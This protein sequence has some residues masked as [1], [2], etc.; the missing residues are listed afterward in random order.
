MCHDYNVFKTKEAADLESQ[1]VPP[2]AMPGFISMPGSSND[3]RE[4]GAVPPEVPPGLPGSDSSLQEQIHALT[5]RITELEGIIEQW[6]P[7]SQADIHDRVQQL[8]HNQDHIFPDL[9]GQVQ[10]LKNNQN[11]GHPDL[12]IRIQE[13]QEAVQ[14]VS[15]QVHEAVQCMEAMGITPSS[16][17]ASN[18]WQSFSKR[19]Y[20]WKKS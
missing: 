11:H 15:E 4:D 8:Q 7:W 10:E 18:P 14:L 1:V 3:G 12:H 16:T 5:E 2:L 6:S 20:E 17:S 19:W 9:F 13:L